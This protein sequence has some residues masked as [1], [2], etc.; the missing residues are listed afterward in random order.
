[1]P[2]GTLGNRFVRL[3]AFEALEPRTLLS[4]VDGLPSI[5][6]L[7]TPTNPVVVFETTL[8]DVYLEL[9]PLDAPNTVANFLQYVQ[10][11]HYSETLVHRHQSNFVVQ[12][13]GYEYTD[14]NGLRRVFD[15]SL[16]PIANEFGRSNQARTIAMAKFGGQP[17]SAT[18]E[19]FINLANNSSSLDNTAQ[20]DNIDSGGFTVFGRILG[21]ASWDVVT[22]IRN[23]T[24]RNLTADP[25]FQGQVEDRALGRPLFRDANNFST[26]TNTGTQDTAN[27]AMNQFPTLGSFSGSFDAADQV[28]VLNAQIVKPQ[29]STSF[30]SQVL[31]YP[32]GYAS[33]QSRMEIDLANTNDSTA[34]VQIVARY[35]VSSGL[36]DRTIF[37]GTLSANSART[38]VVHDTTNFGTSLVRKATPV[39]FEVYTS[40]P[41]TETDPQPVGAA[42]NHFDYTG[43]FSESFFDIS[44]DDQR[45]DTWD[46]AA[47]PASSKSYLV[48]QNTGD[49]ATTVSVTF[50]I[51]G[52]A[53]VSRT[54]NLGAYKRGG[55]RLANIPQLAAIAEGTVVAARIT[56]GVDIV[57][58]ASSYFR[59]T[60]DDNGAAAGGERT[61]RSV[62]GAA[63]VPSGGSIEGIVSGLVRTASGTLT[64][65]AFNAGPNAAVISLQAFRTNGSILT[66]VP[67]AF[68]MAAQSR[69]QV[70]L[71]TVFPTIPL[72]ESYTLRYTSTGPVALSALFLDSSTAMEEATLTPV[73]TRTSDAL[74]F[75][76]GFTTV[77]G[78]VST[79]ETLTVFNPYAGRVLQ[80]NIAY[81]FSDGFV[82][83]E[84]VVLTELGGASFA[85]EANVD[86][87]AKVNSGEQ[88]RNYSII[89]RGSLVSVE[90]APLAVVAGLTRL[91]NRDTGSLDQVIAYGPSLVGS[92]FDLD[93]T[94]FDPG[95][96]G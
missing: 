1:M 83:T 81:V 90:D 18:N 66:A 49:A 24:A 65:A 70:N 2:E 88:F 87:L 77:A 19:W 86:V 25:A 82:V 44:D 28:K 3:P 43:A 42:L 56:A 69:A 68:I 4:A 39:A 62:V 67:A 58:A 22:A 63:G 75:A 16:A 33:F 29:G 73:S 95:L 11:G 91:D 57:A 55:M 38:V 85:T 12:L 47:V 64:L 9:F 13:G 15:E 7:E 53:P 48:W 5:A 60:V 61:F 76:D 59:T 34:T 35:E 51:S 74:A 10:R 41:T 37:S 30:Y 46:F 72:D 26:L 45:S 96:D 52:Q 6:S 20:P 54:F 8:G 78:S 92:I 93:S 31:V 89:V 84:T 27:T 14:T 50:F 71:A 36:R 94:D 17:D 79:R 32:E 23:L 40:L 21:D 80:A